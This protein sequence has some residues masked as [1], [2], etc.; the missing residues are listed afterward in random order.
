MNFTALLPT[1]T[2]TI[3]LVSAFALIMT[4]VTL[5]LGAPAST[6]MLE[7]HAR[8]F[9]VIIL[10]S[11]GFLQFIGVVHTTYSA[12][13]VRAIVTWIVG[14]FWV[15]ISGEYMLDRVRPTEVAAFL[16]GVSNLY[17]FVINLNLLVRG[18]WK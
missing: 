1:D 3:E 16:L 10:A 17:A 12:E 2:R 11:F 14:A 4:S 7:I 6:W 5:L 8:E 13:V 9:W 18:K 15:W